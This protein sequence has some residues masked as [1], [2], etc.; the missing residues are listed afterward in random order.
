MLRTLSRL[1]SLLLLFS[2]TT[3]AEPDEDRAHHEH[4][5]D[6]SGLAWNTNPPLAAGI[7]GITLGP[8]ESSLHPDRGYGTA[9][10][11]DSMAQLDRLGATWVSLT[12]FG[13]IW[14]LEPTGVDLCFEAPVRQNQRAVARAVEQAHAAGLKVMLVP[15]LW[16]ETG[17]WRGE[18]DP[19]DDAGWKIWAR[20][21]ERFLLYW[22]RVAAKNH[23]DMLSLGV[24]LRT[25]VTT[26][27]AA[28]FSEIIK[29]VRKIYP[30]RLTYAANW[31]DAKDTVIWGDLDVIGINAFYPLAE[32]SGASS[33]ELRDRAFTLARTVEELASAWN[34]PIVFT[35]IGYTT[36]AD[37]ALRPWEWPDN[38][39][40]VRIDQVAQAEAY[41]ALIEPFI[42]EP[43]FW[44]FFVW[45]SYAYRYD[46]SQEAEWGFSPLGKQAE[47]VVRDAFAAHWAIDGARP[48]GAS[49]WRDRALRV[50]AY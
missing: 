33:A 43:W 22:A 28:S 12:S 46:M 2:G 19:H 47:L 8:I 21:Y 29:K 23:V 41:R 27:H 44:G 34:K 42:G 17:G 18:I 36:R 4:G 11:A 45:R 30:G 35:E 7:R 48:L 40:D 37:P 24:E 13:R 3:S 5:A 1:L 25:W 15:H 9:A 39:T 10:S 38:M 50:A 14:D 16:T 6:E 20:G 26:T 31:D 32:R 49:L